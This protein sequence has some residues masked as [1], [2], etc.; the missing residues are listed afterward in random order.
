MSSLYLISPR[1][2]EICEQ[3]GWDDQSL[4]NRLLGF[5]Q[6]TA[7]Q[8]VDIGQ[9]L[10][11]WF[12]DRAK[13][14]NEPVEPEAPILMATFIGQEWRGKRD[15]QA[16]EVEGSRCTFPVTA[17]DIRDLTGFDPDDHHDPDGILDE[18][19]SNP[20]RRDELCRAAAAP[21]RLRY[22]DGPFEIDLEACPGI[23]NE[24]GSPS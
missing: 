18:I 22:W 17:R 20:T 11:I 8:D 13:E 24:P 23:E 5:I 15:D 9:E 3:Q 19:N 1:A 12:E 10:A 14:E 7:P 6:H 21:S 16:H 2:Q 4:I